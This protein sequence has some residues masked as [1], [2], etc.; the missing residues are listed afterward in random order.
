MSLSIE[1]KKRIERKMTAPVSM[2]EASEFKEQAISQTFIIH[3]GKTGHGFSKEVR[4]LT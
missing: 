4:F 3:K 2:S 1:T